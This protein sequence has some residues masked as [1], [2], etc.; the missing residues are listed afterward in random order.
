MGFFS[1]I[2][3]R[4][5]DDYEEYED[6]SSGGVERTLEL[7]NGMPLE[8]ETPEGVPLFGGRVSGY[9]EGDT[10]LTLERQPGGLSLK[11][12]ELGTGVLLR[13]FDENMTQFVLKGTVQESTRLVCRL[14]DVKIRPVAEQRHDF[15][16]HM[17][18][19]AILYNMADET[20]NNPEQCVLVDISVGGA[21]L[22]SEFLHGEDE[23]LR[24]KFKL[25]NYAPMEY[26]GEIIR[27]VEYQPGK[28]RYGFLFA[29]LSE[30]ELTDLTRT[31]YNIQVG[32]RQ[33][34]ARKLPG[35]P[36]H[37]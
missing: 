16:L 2:F 26:M 20:R 27:V 5:D 32:N 25:E 14:K 30:P 24:L 37:W 23:V 12:R 4:S 10:T 19:P 34:W 8:V 11:I 31:L 29:Q 3:G 35:E 21:C 22:E 18:A 33:P 9:T 7:H 1:K 28:F 36:G 15:R 17:N 6:E 13:G